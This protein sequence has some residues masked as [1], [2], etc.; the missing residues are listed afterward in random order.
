M[1]FCLTGRR[2]EGYQQADRQVLAALRVIQYFLDQ[3]KHPERKGCPPVARPF[4]WVLEYPQTGELKNRDFMQGKQYADV[5]YCHYGKK[6]QKHTRSG[7]TLQ[8]FH[9]L[10]AFIR[11]LHRSSAV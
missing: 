8:R 6:K 1:P 11:L 7:T 5:S 9:T 2:E 4:Q 3:S 10:L